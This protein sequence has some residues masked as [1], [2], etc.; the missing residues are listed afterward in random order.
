MDIP[1]KWIALRSVE[2]QR[3]FSNSGSAQLAFLDLPN[4]MKIGQITRLA[5][6][7][8]R[9]GIVNYDSARALGALLGMQP[10]TI[11][12]NLKIMED[13]TWVSVSKNS[14]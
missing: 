4:V 1:E 14:F 2:I 6:M 5:N 10:D 9:R 7:L 13:L 3:C 8:R 11:L 12:Y